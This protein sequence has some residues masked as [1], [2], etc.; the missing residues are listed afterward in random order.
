MFS[1]KLIDNQFRVYADRDIKKGELWFERTESNSLVFSRAQY[2]TLSKSEIE[3]HESGRDLYQCIKNYTLYDKYHDHLVLSLEGAGSCVATQ[4]KLAAN[5]RFVCNA[6]RATRDI[7]VDEE[8]VVLCEY[9]W[10]E[11]W[12]TAPVGGYTTSFYT[13]SHPMEL[14]ETPMS[15]LK[16][17]VGKCDVGVGVFVGRDCKAGEKTWVDYPH[18]YFGVS[19]EQYDML[20]Q[21]EVFKEFHQCIVLFANYDHKVDKLMVCLDNERYKNHSSAPEIDNSPL[22]DEG[23]TFLQRDAQAHTEI[24][25][26]YFTYHNCPWASVYPSHMAEWIQP[27]KQKILEENPDMEFI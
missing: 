21:C 8:L 2:Y 27:L 22:F 20:T 9:V 26:S 23:Y 7:A 13:S 3:A 10:P 19:K 16:M 24:R 11:E 18:L 4:S 25:E 17:Y 15:A 12:K 5:S 14:P 1:V 6:A